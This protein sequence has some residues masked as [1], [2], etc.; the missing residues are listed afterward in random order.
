MQSNKARTKLLK[1]AQRV[2]LS[3]V[4]TSITIVLD[5]LHE[6]LDC[7]VTISKP[8]W[9][10]MSAPLMAIVETALKKAI[11]AAEEAVV[12]IN[13]VLLNGAWAPTFLKVPIEKMIPGKLKNNKGRI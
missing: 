11:E 3:G 6:G 5:G 2:L 9:E 1:E 4:G 12:E 8:R 10:L 7:N 13:Q